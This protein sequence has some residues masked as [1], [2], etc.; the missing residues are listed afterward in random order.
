[1]ALSC[2]RTVLFPKESV[3]W[4]PRMTLS[5]ENIHWGPSMTLSREKYS[6]GS[7]HD[8]KEGKKLSLG[9][10]HDFKQGKLSLGPPH[11]FKWGNKIAGF[12]GMTL[13]SVF[14]CAYVDISFPPLSSCPWRAVTRVAVMDE[15]QRVPEVV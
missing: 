9:P 6:L 12:H 7:L 1:M 4:V 15:A 5:R 8:F 11:D 14:V 2:F 13:L 3:H 10:P